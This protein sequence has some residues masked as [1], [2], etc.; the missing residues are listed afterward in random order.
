MLEFIIR[1]EQDILSAMTLNQN[2]L[3]DGLNVLSEEMFTDSDH[4][5]W[6]RSIKEIFTQSK[7]V[8]IYEVVNHAATNYNADFNGILRYITNCTDA[9]VSIQEIKSTLTL[10]KDKYKQRSLSELY[11]NAYKALSEPNQNVNDV[12]FSILNQTQDILKESQ[13]GGLRKID[14]ALQEVYMQCLEGFK[15][16]NYQPPNIRKTGFSMFDQLVEIKEE[17][18]VIIGAR[19]AMGK[20]AFVLNIALN[21]AKQK[22]ENSKHNYVIALFSLEMSNNSLVKRL[23][24]NNSGVNRKKLNCLDN[25]ELSVVEKTIEEMQ[26][27]DFYLDDTSNI[28]PSYLRSEVSK[29]QKQCEREG[30][31]LGAVFV[32]YLGLM[33][34][35]EAYYNSS[36]NTDVSKISKAHK[37][38]ARELKVP[39]VALAQLSRQVEQRAN[40]RP[41]LSDLRDSGSLEQ[42][43]DLVMFLYRD[44]YYNLDSPK[45]RIADVIVAKNREGETFTHDLYFD[46]ALTRFAELERGVI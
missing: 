24:S 4:K 7:Q 32:D 22:P 5:L 19:P 44:E 38:L 31:K 14:H 43:A 3:L 8:T 15:N 41:Q 33:S 37:I 34:T 18:F 2:S 11:F 46:G 40:K 36:T 16:P 30:K 9:V 29:L 17:D 10:F 25:F 21:I 12:A 27:L 28:T 23:V 20:T 1:L 45:K 26:G 39:V 6:F 35:D 42:D 13:K